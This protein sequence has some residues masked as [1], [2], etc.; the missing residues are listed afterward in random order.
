MS[1]LSVTAVRVGTVP[2]VELRLRLP[3]PMRGPREVAA[4]EAAAEA[5]FGRAAP[6]GA[7]LA[8]YGACLVAAAD[9]DGLCL[10]AAAP[11]AALGL[12]LSRIADV[13]ARRATLEEAA[14]RTAVRELTAAARASEDDPEALATAAA[15]RCAYGDESAYA[16]EWAGAGL[17]ST[18]DPEE[19]RAAS[20]AVTTAGGKAVVVGDVIPETATALVERSLDGIGREPV[21]TAPVVPRRG[22]PS[23]LAL[24][25]PGAVQSALRR[26]LVLPPEPAGEAGL[27]GW[28]TADLVLG[29]QPASR[30]THTLRERHGHAYI[31][32][33]R[34]VRRPRAA[35]LRVI[36]D[37]GLAATARSVA[38]VEEVTRGMA[39]GVTDAERTAAGHFAATALVMSRGG[40]S[41]LAG[42]LSQEMGLGRTPDAVER[43]ERLL[44]AAD[45]AAVDRAARL[46]A[47]GTWHTAL[48]TDLN[49]VDPGDLPELSG[50]GWT[51]ADR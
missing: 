37:V 25:R 22:A 13:L 9:Q 28:R 46:M 50:T 45:G 35:D 3:M 40:Q 49:R 31:A 16:H 34:L 27:A 43:D 1:D 7:E 14:V 10:A 33:S 15:L 12:L 2:L 8:R 47:A 24:H 39:D 20:A 42:L 44:A 18:L 4:A 23:N 11:A 6:I 32:R 29:G 38:L 26:V 19:V 30:L 51:T 17:L 36:A 21:P 41:D 5:L 48:V